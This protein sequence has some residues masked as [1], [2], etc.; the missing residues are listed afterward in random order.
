MILQFLDRYRNLGLLIL[1]VG[2]GLFVAFMHGWD[3]ITGGPGMW[4]ELG[5]TMDQVF[6]IGFLPTFWGFMAA[7]AEFVGGLLVVLGLLFRPA[8]ILLILNMATAATM[9]IT[10]GQ[11]SP[12]LA[13]VYGIAWLAL[14]FT[15]PG[16][17]SLDAQF[18]SSSGHQGAARF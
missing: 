12:E 6:G 5:G 2:L 11:G 18:G 13:L 8:L 9:H 17:Y 1:R 7:V 10:T 16:R 14:F 4:T 3:K 15:G